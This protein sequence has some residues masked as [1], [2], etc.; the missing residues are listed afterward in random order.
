MNETIRLLIA[1]CF[2]AA[3][4]LVFILAVV[5]TYKFDFVLNR[6]HCASLADTLGLM[7]ML[8][9]LGFLAGRWGIVPKLLLILVFQWIGSPIASHMLSRM[10][11]G[12]DPD[13][14]NHLSVSPAEGD[15]EKG[16]Q[17]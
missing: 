9:G 12:I 17:K 10:E 5:G 3:G 16:E 1:G 4:L 13:L 2:L 15:G 7:L 11:V 6:M 14:E 8:I